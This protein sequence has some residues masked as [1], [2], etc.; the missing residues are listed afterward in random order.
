M[1]KRFYGR[2]ESGSMHLKTG[3]LD[4]VVTIAGY[5]HTK[6]GKTFIV[7]ML[8]NQSGIHRGPGDEL[9]EALL[10]WTYRQS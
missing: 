7:C 2:P 10:A 9:K 6:S 8:A 1:R 5:V 3:R 4:N